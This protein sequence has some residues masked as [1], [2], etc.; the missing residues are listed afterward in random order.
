MNHKACCICGAD[1][2][3]FLYYGRGYTLWWTV[4]NGDGEPSW[5][6]PQCQKNA[7]NAGVIGSESMHEWVEGHAVNLN[8][9]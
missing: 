6:C 3:Q 5:L 4:G 1:E 7:F 9:K 8:S 2:R